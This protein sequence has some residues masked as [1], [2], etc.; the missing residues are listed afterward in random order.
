MATT[1]ILYDVAFLLMDLWHYQQYDLANFL[2][3]RYLDA[4]DE[5]EGLVLLPLFM[6]LRAS[7]RAMVLAI[8]AANTSNDTEAAK[9]RQQAEQ[10]L[11]L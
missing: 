8:Q 7:I 10:F 9:Y 6:S 4:Q 2:M 5:T 3:N 1:D 11:D